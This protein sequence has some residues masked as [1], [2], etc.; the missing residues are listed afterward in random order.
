MLTNVNQFVQTEETLSKIFT[1]LSSDPKNRNYYEKL[2]IDTDIRL[3]DN[4]GTNS[5]CFREEAEKW[6]KDVCY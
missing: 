6:L 5:P 4:T 1:K 2:I 3:S